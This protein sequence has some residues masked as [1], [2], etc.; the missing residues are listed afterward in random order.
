MRLLMA[1]QLHAVRVRRLSRRRC[2][3]WS[4]RANLHGDLMRARDR[5]SLLAADR[6]RADRMGRAA[7]E[8]VLGRFT[9]AACAARCLAAYEELLAP[10]PTG[11]R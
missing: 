1:G 4:V 8:L 2:S 6:G 7:R 11:A 9:W 10:Q 3:T 5:V